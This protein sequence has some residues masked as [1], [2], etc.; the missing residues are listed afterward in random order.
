MANA[1]LGFRTHSG[2]AVAVAVAGPRESPTII[3]RRRIALGES[4][5]E[6]RQ[7]YH[8]AQKLD[9]PA[10]AALIGCHR[11][12]SQTSARTEL[13]AILDELHG[14]NYELIG[15]GM[16]LGSG[17]P[18]GTLESTLASHA[19]IHTAEGE[20]FRDAIAHACASCGLS[21]RG[22]RERELYSL[23][24]RELKLSDAQLQR[25]LAGFGRCIGRPW[26][27]DEKYAAIA[28]WLAL[29]A[30]PVEDVRPV[31]PL[32]SHPTRPTRSARGQRRL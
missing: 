16:L 15:C 21:L 18:L 31:R 10:A 20:F 24:T 1:A 11:Q 30:A 17:R 23:A 28:A 12:I 13:L 9:L 27:Q 19:L 7:P 14:K 29:A 8:A 25:Q 26:R 5:P 2:W 6:A 4:S 32:S 22:M 3:D